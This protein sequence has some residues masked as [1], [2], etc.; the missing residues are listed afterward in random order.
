MTII[1]KSTTVFGYHFGH[2]HTQIDCD[3]AKKPDLID[4]K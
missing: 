3:V 2:F 1:S 4:K